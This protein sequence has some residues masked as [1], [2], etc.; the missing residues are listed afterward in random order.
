M[1]LACLAGAWLFVGQA[2]AG[3]LTLTRTQTTTATSFNL[4]AEGDLDWAHWGSF[5]VTDFDYPAGG[6]P[7]ISNYTPVG[8]PSYGQYSDDVTQCSWVDGTVDQ[9]ETDLSS[10]IWASGPDTGYQLTIPA[11]TTPRVLHLYIGSWNKSGTLELSLSDNSTA[12]VT[13]IIPNTTTPSCHRHVCRQF[14]R[15]VPNGE[16][17]L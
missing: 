6:T 13:N 10:G 3:T 2:T 8:I 17:S 15:S 4:S 14:G 12:S 5:A 16:L 9:A 11:S 1:L 7:Q